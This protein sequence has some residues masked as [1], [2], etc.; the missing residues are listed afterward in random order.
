MP[1]PFNEKM[2]HGMSPGQA[3]PER[4]KFG[5]QAY[6]SSS[7]LN[8]FSNGGRYNEGPDRRLPMVDRV[9]GVGNTYSNIPLSE[10]VRKQKEFD[11]WE[12]M[13]YLGENMVR[14]SPHYID[15]FIPS[16]RS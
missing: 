1:S 7:G 3:Q 8:P 16:Y 2:L 11:G 5:F 14:S 4:I 9:K 15:I 6:G 10:L 12:E 13:Q